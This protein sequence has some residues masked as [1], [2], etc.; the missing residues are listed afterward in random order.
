MPREQGELIFFSRGIGS[1]LPQNQFSCESCHWDRLTDHRIHYGGGGTQGLIRPARGIGMVSHPMPDMEYDSI[2][3]LVEEFFKAM[4]YKFWSEPQLPETHWQKEKILY[5]EAD[6][7][8]KLSAQDARLALLTYLMRLPAES[9]LLRSPGKEFSTEAR[10]GFDIFWRDCIRCH[11][12]V[13]NMRT[14]K[15]MAKAEALAHLKHNP[16]VFGAPLFTKTAV[17]HAYTAHGTRI[18]PL[19]NLGRGGPYLTRGAAQTLADI[20]RRTNP[21]T[22]EVHFA[23]N[24]A[25]FYS[26]AEIAALTAF[27]LAI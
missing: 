19:T 9:P 5:P 8:V 23:D 10:G 11:E 12:P 26:P 7:P 1:D 13:M 16:L 20:L 22:N 27:L 18:N 4:D 2:A 14:R 24:S 17:P 25:V 6:T 21:K 15:K 3:K